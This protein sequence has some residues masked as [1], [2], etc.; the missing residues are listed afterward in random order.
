MFE[1]IIIKKVNQYIS[2][3]KV[4]FFYNEFLFYFIL[5]LRR[6]LMD[7]INVIP[8]HLIVKLKQYEMGHF[9]SIL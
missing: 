2:L 6:K 4:F 3:E 5:F 7:F 1:K 8:L 9:P